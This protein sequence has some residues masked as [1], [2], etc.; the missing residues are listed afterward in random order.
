MGIT[1]PLTCE[2]RTL[3][4][5]IAFGNYGAGSCPVSFL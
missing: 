2:G 5:G 1:M 4:R 3:A